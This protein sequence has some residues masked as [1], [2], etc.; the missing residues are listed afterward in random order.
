MSGRIGT[1]TN[2]VTAKDAGVTFKMKRKER[3]RLNAISRQR[4]ELNRLAARKVD[5]RPRL[6][7]P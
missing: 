2:F 1:A 4:R 5:M 6:V 3:E 7:K